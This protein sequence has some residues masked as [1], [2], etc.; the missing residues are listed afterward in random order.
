MGVAVP[1]LK[2]LGAVQAASL[3]V[4]APRKTLNL[5]SCLV[6][7]KFLCIGLCS[8]FRVRGFRAQPRESQARK[9]R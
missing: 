2:G 7:K 3:R 9:P 1:S 8:E 4:L 5:D 6:L